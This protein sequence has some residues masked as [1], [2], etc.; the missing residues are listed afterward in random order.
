MSVLETPRIYF[1]GEMTWD[2]ITTNNYDDNYNEDSGE[3]IFPGAVDRVRAFRDNAVT[4]VVTAVSWNPQGTHRSTFFNTRV[5]GCDL[6]P[7]RPSGGDPFLNAAVN[8]TGMLVDVEPFGAFTSQ[9]FFDRM[10]FGF[11]GGYFLHAPSRRRFVDRYL[12]FNRNPANGMIAGRA[13]VVWQT[14]FAKAEGLRIEAYDSPALQALAAALDADDVLGLTCRFNTYNTIYYDNPAL[15]NG[16]PAAREE[17]EALVVK[18]RSGGFQPNPAR[19][20]LVGVV[21]LWR[22][23]EPAQEPVDR[24]LVPVSPAQ[25]L[26]N[27]WVRISE[28]ALTLD[29]SNSVPETG[30]NLDKLDA[31]PL[32]VTAS[33][34]DPASGVAAITLATI[35]YA[36]YN[37]PAYEASAGIIVVPLVPA[38]ARAAAGMNL[39]LQSNAG[40]LTEETLRA[41][42]A[43]PDLYLDEG[44][45]AEAAFQVWERGRPAQRALALTLY[46]MSANGGSLDNS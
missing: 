38:I 36:A 31:G 18:L 39:S 29:L 24:V 25:G 44:Q 32:T 23:G 10:G 21:G 3:T 46:Q 35:P 6:G 8:F 40:N 42:S 4:Q 28:N 17:A 13:S 2:P 1:Q 33:D 9:L 19:S 43:T 11:G 30:A 34:P 20:R 22:R 7:G 5:C 27:A 16:S 45:S 37:R 15:S 26:A 14:S 41:V 12:N